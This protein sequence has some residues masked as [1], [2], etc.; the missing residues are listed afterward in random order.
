MSDDIQ[1]ETSGRGWTEQK[2]FNYALARSHAQHGQRLQREENSNP[3]SEGEIVWGDALRAQE[4]C[5]IARL[6]QAVLLSCWQD[7][8]MQ[9]LLT[10]VVPQ[11]AEDANRDLKLFGC[12]SP[13]YCHNEEKI[14]TSTASKQ[15]SCFD[16][17]GSFCNDSHSLCMYLL[18]SVLRKSH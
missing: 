11:L 12:C 1:G 9:R 15:K 7:T 18:F 8:E 2:Q 14:Y 17:R 3:I 4:H 10:S 6:R 5:G 13:L 16:I